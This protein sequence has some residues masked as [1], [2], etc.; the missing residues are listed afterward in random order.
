MFT[1]WGHAWQWHLRYQHLH[2]G[3][4]VIPRCNERITKVTR[5]MFCL[6]IVQFSFAHWTYFSIANNFIHL[7]IRTIHVDITVSGIEIETDS[8]ARFNKVTDSFEFRNWLATGHRVLKR[9]VKFRVIHLTVDSR[10]I[11]T[12][13]YFGN[14]FVIYT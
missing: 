8:Y 1:I 9:V 13:N 10:F 5:A 6:L 2:V 12:L 3:T 7:F 11:V 4:T 14:M